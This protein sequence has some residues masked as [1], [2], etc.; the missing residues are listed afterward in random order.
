MADKK[1]YALRFS[2]FGGQGVVLASI[3]F[4][5]ALAAEGYNV[6]QTQSF[7]IE[8][9]G[10][11][12]RGEVLCGR[13]KLNYLKVVNPDILVAMT[14]LACDTYLKDLTPDGLL[15][16][17]SFYVEKVPA[18]TSG[19]TYAV[20]FTT[21]AQQELGKALFANIIFLGFLNGVTGLVAP[22]KLEEAVLN[23]VAPR[24]HDQ[25]RRALQIGYE[26]AEKALAN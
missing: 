22:E 7:G 9:R 6:L 24:F 17:D 14:Q 19:K 2:G 13:E 15:I 1:K 3:I 4:A 18:R 26:E 5:E 8:A 10:G 23:R 16:C 11:A 21:L 25:N 12:S 20:P